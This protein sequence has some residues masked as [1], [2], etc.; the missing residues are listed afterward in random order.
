M[1]WEERIGCKHLHFMSKEPSIANVESRCRWMPR[2][3]CQIRVLEV[4]PRKD[5][6]CKNKASHGVG[7]LIHLKTSTILN[8][9]LTTSI[10][11]DHHITLPGV[12]PV[13]SPIFF[14]LQRDRMFEL[15]VTLA[16]NREQIGGRH[17]HHD[18]LAILE[19]ESILSRI[20][21]SPVKTKLG[22]GDQEALIFFLN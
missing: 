10:R 3:G 5:A 22:L 16:G 2:N 1:G 19:P 8:P 11:F 7:R 21:R 13:S 14:N 9:G 15:I 18:E 17:I 12:E 6:E 4:R 20:K